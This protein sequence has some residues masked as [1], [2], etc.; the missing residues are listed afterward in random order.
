V[1]HCSNYHDFDDVSNIFW[2][3]P[4][5]IKLFNTFYTVL[6]LDSTYKTNKYRLLL[7]EFVG[8]TSTQLT[9]SIGFA[10]MMYEK[11]EHVTWALERCRELLHSK[12]LYPN[13][14]VVDRDNA[15]MNVVDI[16]FHEATALLCEYHIERNARA[17]CKTDCKVKDLKGKDGKDIKPN[18]TVKTIM[19]AWEDTVDSDTEEA[20]VDDCN[21]FK[22]VCEKWPKFVEYVE[23]T[24]LGPV[25]EKI[26]KF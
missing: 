10:Y 20:Y 12:D 25:K 7:L 1:Y 21:R 24:I 13:I 14:V 3:H 5:G 8:N 16:V 26:V 22:V 11:E 4:D 9:F 17:K 2:A 6:V 18:S 15:L 19:R 23:S